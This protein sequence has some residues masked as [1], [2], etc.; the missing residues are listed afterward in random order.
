[1]TTGQINIRNVKS[2]RDN[3]SKEIKMQK[4]YLEGRK[5]SDGL[6]TSRTRL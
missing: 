3:G 4:E 2:M 1:M 6:C 5:I